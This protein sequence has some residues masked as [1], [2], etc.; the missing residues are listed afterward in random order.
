MVGVP[1]G[2]AESRYLG[3]AGGGGAGGG[4]S[5]EAGDGKA[6]PAADTSESCSAWASQGECVSNAE[7]MLGACAT[8]CSNQPVEEVQHQTP[9][10]EAEI[11]AAEEA[12]LK[13]KEEVEAAAAVARGYEFARAF[14]AKEKAASDASK[15]AEATTPPEVTKP[16]AKHAKVPPVLEAPPILN[17]PPTLTAGE[18]AAAKA[19]REKA[20]KEKAALKTRPALDSSLVTAPTM[21][22]TTMVWALASKRAS[23][24]VGIS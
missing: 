3:G 6:P 14:A 24:R 20:A 8:S 4:A 12:A 19:A 22:T 7:Y 5:G 23:I 1:V 11:A 21:D 15:P 17:T 9:P 16:L 18:V 10:D 13:E 2:E